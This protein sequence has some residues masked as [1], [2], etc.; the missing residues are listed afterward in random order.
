MNV[1][2]V[3]QRLLTA[4]VVLLGVTFAVFLIIQLVPGDPARVI[5]GVQ[6]NE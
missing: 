2:Y 5:L 6:A 4:L 1:Q 3:A